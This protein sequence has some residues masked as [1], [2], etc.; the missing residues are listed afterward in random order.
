MQVNRLSLILYMLLSAVA[1]RADVQLTEKKLAG[2][3]S[4]NWI[5]E[6]VETVMGSGGCTQG[7]TWR[8]SADHSVEIRKCID[9]KL[10]RQQ[11]SWS[12][13][14]E[15]SLDTVITVGAMQ[16]YLTFYKRAGGSYMLLKSI[17]NRKL[18]GRVNKEFRLEDE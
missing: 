15:S 18:D 12:L 11:N 5:A 3:T 17:S 14:E 7:E 6:R 4:Q 9:R 10:T 13:A 1:S 2:D 8:F 16:Y